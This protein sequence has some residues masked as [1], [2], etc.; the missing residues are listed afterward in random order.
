MELNVEDD[1]AGF[2]RVLIKK[3]DGERIELTWT[4]LI[5]RILEVMGIEGANSKST[6]VETE[7]LPVDKTGNLTEPPFIYASVIGM[8]NITRTY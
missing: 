2:F 6:P 5:N 4:G 3:L 8:L 7:A 1:V